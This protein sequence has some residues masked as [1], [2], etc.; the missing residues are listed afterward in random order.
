MHSS[1]GSPLRIL[2]TL[3][4]TLLSPMLSRYACHC[5][6]IALLAGVGIRASA[7]NV[8]AQTQSIAAREAARYTAQ[9]NA[10]ERVLFVDE[11]GNN[12]DIQH[13]TLHLKITPTLRAIGAGSY[14]STRF[15]W[16]GA[17]RSDLYFDMSNAL[18]LDSVIYHG[19]QLFAD[20]SELNVLRLAVPALAL[21]GSYDSIRFHYHGVPD[22]SAFGGFFKDSHAGVPIIFTLSESYTARTWWPCKADLNDKVDSLDMYVDC[23][24]TQKVGGNGLLAEILP[25]T[26]GRHIYHWRERYPIVNYLIAFTVTNYVEYTYKFK[27]GADSLLFQNYLYPESNNAGTR[28]LID[29]LIPVLRIYDSLFGG[30]PYK[31]EKY[32]QAQWNWGGGEEQMTMS[33]VSGFDISLIAHELAHQWFGDKVTCGTWRDIWLN[34]GFATYCEGLSRLYTGRT[35]DWENWKSQTLASIISSPGGSVYVDDTTDEGRIF[36]GRLSYAKGA[37]VLHGLRGILGDSAFYAGVRNYMTDPALA[38]GYGRTADLK[39]HLEVSSGKDITEYLA[40]YYYGQGHPTY[41]L[42][43]EQ[44]T[45]DSLT[46]LMTQRQS[47]PSVG[48]FEN[49]VPVKLF[50][51]NGTADTVYFNNTYNGQRFTIPVS[52]SVGN[53]LFDP[54]RWVLARGLVVRG[55]TGIAAPGT[56]HLSIV[57]NPARHTVRIK[58]LPNANTEA[59][60]E[61]IDGNG[62]M[63]RS[64]HTK[65]ASF[66]LDGLP[67]ATYTLRVRQ[68]SFQENVRVVLER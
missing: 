55:A 5:L 24:S 68:G 40:D 60:V 14:V 36:D 66:S 65:T 19:Q 53:L 13:Q 18:A 25:S 21:P 61:V 50:Y 57:P 56:R 17:N 64:G 58:G 44:R 52:D 35:S 7:Q 46:I 62:R 8:K 20:R 67:K 10:N 29:D 28:Q 47:D 41:T 30:Y 43:Y 49:R 22:P 42:T 23:P 45:H 9:R 37:F 27:L 16:I 26:T 6:L 51:M 2:L 3:L 39:R 11:R 54:E 48:F 32:G 59:A 33:F 38:Y 12:V 1:F 63:M 4:L 15:R 31:R 34:E